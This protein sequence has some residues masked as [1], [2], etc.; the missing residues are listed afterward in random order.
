M[1]DSFP[2][3]WN[4]SSV[5]LPTLDRFIWPTFYEGDK[6]PVIEIA[7]W[8]QGRGVW[9]PLGKLHQ[10]G[11]MLAGEAKCRGVQPPV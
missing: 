11:T 7:N 4:Q 1:N 8:S 9:C 3:L 6:P 2:P 5:I 10:Q